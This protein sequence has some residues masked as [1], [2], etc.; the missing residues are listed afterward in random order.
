MIQREEEG[1]Q[2]SSG[3]VE[4]TDHFPKPLSALNCLSNISKWRMFTNMYDAQTANA[5]RIGSQLVIGRWEYP[6]MHLGG[7]HV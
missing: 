1:T 4:A 3:T 5:V 7:H 6:P 2:Q